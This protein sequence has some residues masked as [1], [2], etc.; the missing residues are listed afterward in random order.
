MF[1]VISLVVVYP[2]Y[3]RIKLR[4][5]IDDAIARRKSCF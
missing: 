3:A 1:L 2:R 5:Q 4:N